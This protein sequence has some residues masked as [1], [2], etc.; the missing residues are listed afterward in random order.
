MFK[1]QNSTHVNPT[2]LVELEIQLK[3]E[4]ILLIFLGIVG[5][6]CANDEEIQALKCQRQIVS[7][8]QCCDLPV[9][10]PNVTKLCVKE[11]KDRQ[12]HAGILVNLLKFQ[13]QNFL[14]E[15]SSFSAFKNVSTQSR[16]YSQQ[17]EN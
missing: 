12:L 15:F 3:M 4:Q 14:I 2:L 16:D 5:I 17:R 11:F 13:N 1:S 6:F 9:M 10:D 7:M 8:S